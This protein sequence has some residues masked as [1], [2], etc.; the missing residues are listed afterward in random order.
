MSFLDELTGDFVV[1]LRTAP[2]FLAGLET[3]PAI[4]SMIGSG[5]NARIFAEQS[6]LGAAMPQIV[7]TMVSGHSSKDLAGVDGCQDLTLHVYAYSDAQVESLRLARAIHK[8]TIAHASNSIWGTGTGVHVCNGGIVDSGRDPAG[9]QSD[10]K[11]Y[12]QRL[13]LR[14]VIS[15]KNIG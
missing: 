4:A 5:E 2:S 13:V 10:R 8:R 11:H 1:H 3:I 14:M 12:W 6:R 9:D 15:E 7:Y